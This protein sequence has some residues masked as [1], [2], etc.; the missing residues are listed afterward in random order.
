[1]NNEAHEWRQDCQILWKREKIYIPIL[2]PFTPEKGLII[3]PLFLAETKIFWCVGNFDASGTRSTLVYSWQ[4]GWRISLG[5]SQLRSRSFSM[6]CQQ[7]GL[8]KYSNFLESHQDRLFWVGVDGFVREWD[9]CQILSSHDLFLDV[10]WRYG[11]FLIKLMCG[12]QDHTSKEKN[13][14]SNNFAL[15]ISI[16]TVSQ[17][18]LVKSIISGL[19][20]FLQVQ[21]PLSLAIVKFSHFLLTGYGI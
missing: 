9:H 11:G 1:M 7:K 19:Y 5:S 16:L 6:F 10:S 4:W 20:L 2:K 15:Y 3:W 18:I 13:Q 8:F 21:L 12:S 17:T 14:L